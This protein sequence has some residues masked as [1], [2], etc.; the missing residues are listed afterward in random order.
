MAVRCLPTALLSISLFV[1]CRYARPMATPRSVI[2]SRVRNWREY[3][4]GLCQTRLRQ[5]GEAERVFLTIL[6]SAVA[7]VSNTQT[8]TGRGKESPLSERYDFIPVGVWVLEVP[9]FII[10]Q[11]K[12]C[13]DLPLL[14]PHIGHVPYLTPR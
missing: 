2:R 5:K 4:R 3:N 8:G 7:E 9:H 12:C 10:T 6:L 14:K 11:Q 1:P 13:A